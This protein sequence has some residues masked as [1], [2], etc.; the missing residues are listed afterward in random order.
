M[1]VKAKKPA[2]HRLMQAVFLILEGVPMLYIQ[3][4]S[5]NLPALALDSRCV[6]MTMPWPL[7]V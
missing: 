6:N 3:E 7:K 2:F 4:L 1:C 5:G